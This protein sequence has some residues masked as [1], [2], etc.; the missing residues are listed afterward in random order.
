MST[1]RST[2]LPLVLSFNPHCFTSL[3]VYILNLSRFNHS[4]WKLPLPLGYTCT[5]PKAYQA[6][7]CS[8]GWSFASSTT[9]LEKATLSHW[10]E[11]MHQATALADLLIQSLSSTSVGYFPVIFDAL[12]IPLHWLCTCHR[13]I[14]YSVSQQTEWSLLTSMFQGLMSRCE[15]KRWNASC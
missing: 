3:K 12:Y 9:R 2:Q 7:S 6:H 15:R 1:S 8:L 11:K 10:E 13:S 5:V 4:T 14:V